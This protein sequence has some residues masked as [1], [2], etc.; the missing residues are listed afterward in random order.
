MQRRVFQVLIEFAA[1][2]EAAREMYWKINMS[3]L[4]IISSSFFL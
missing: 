2:F 4:V 3:L 1:Y